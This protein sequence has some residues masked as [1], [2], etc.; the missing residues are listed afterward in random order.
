MKWSTEGYQGVLW[1]HFTVQSMTAPAFKRPLCW[2]SW[3]SPLATG[4]STGPGEELAVVCM[5]ALHMVSFLFENC[6]NQNARRVKV[7]SDLIF[8]AEGNTTCCWLTNRQ[9]DWLTNLLTNKQTNWLPNSKELRVPQ[10][11]KKIPEFCGPP[12]AH[13]RF[14]KIPTLVSGLS[15]ITP[16]HFS[17]P[18]FEEPPISA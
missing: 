4:C 12:K 13:Y 7:S 18:I 9:T 6:T 3:L 17:L 8:N 2:S 14:H 10:L 16:F 11:I 15:Q 5:P 1:L